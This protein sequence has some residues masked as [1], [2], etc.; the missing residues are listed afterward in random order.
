MVTSVPAP[1]AAPGAIIVV[2]NMAGT[3]EMFKVVYNE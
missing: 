2:G 1:A 3:S